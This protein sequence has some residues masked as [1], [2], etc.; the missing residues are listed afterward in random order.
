M[1]NWKISRDDTPVK[2]C[3]YS[4]GRSCRSSRW[5]WWL[6]G[7]S[8]VRWLSSLRLRSCSRLWFGPSP[9]VKK[10]KRNASLAEMSKRFTQWFAQWSAPRRRCLF[11]R[12]QHF[13]PVLTTPLNQPVPW[14]PSQISMFLKVH[15]E[16]HWQWL[17]QDLNN[18]DKGW[19]LSSSRQILWL[20]IA[21]TSSYI[22]VVW[23]S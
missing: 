11:C 3:L 20:T 21:D 2:K 10:W 17:E 12:I 13:W 18:L 1:T 23:T 16:K 22:D 7:F 9:P 19:Q 6:V 15:Q 4:R 14:S 8:F 5:W